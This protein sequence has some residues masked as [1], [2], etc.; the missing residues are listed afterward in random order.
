[1]KDLSTKF[2]VVFTLAKEYKGKEK[3]MKTDLVL[4]MKVGGRKFGWGWCSRALFK[5]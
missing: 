4:Y 1:L 3:G 5:V 2:S